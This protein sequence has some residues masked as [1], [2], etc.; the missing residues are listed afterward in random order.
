M[1]NTGYDFYLNNLKLPFA[2]PSLEIKVGNRNETVTLINQ[3][4][5]N[6]LK[7]P[8]LTEVSFEMRLP[9]Q[10]YPFAGT[11]NSV[12]TYTDRL[13]EW[14]TN[15]TPI[16]FIVVRT[17]GNGEV[18]FDTNLTMSVEEWTMNEDSNEG[19]DVLID[20]TLKQYKEYGVR[21]V[22]VSQSVKTTTA[23]NSSTK[24]AKTSGTSYTIVPGDNLWKISKR[25][26]GDGSQW[27]K[28]YNANKTVIEERAAK[29]S[30]KTSN[31]G[32]WIF[33]GT[34]LIIP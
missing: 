34:K 24:V 30:K 8:A 21:T 26:Y 33:P 5:I 27:R 3:G 18:L 19:F 17:R 28:I 16:Q 6:I 7:S 1:A 4:E 23:R 9:Q 2:P 13:K 14:K 31:D 32:W 20:V 11:L 25:F 29:S 15:K 12:Q 10:Q 22:A